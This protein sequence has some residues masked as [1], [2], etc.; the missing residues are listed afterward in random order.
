MET[1]E[2]KVFTNKQEYILYCIIICIATSLLFYPYFKWLMILWKNDPYNTFGYIIPVVSVWII[3]ARK[4]GIFSKSVSYTKWGWVAFLGGLALA[5]FYRWN[6]QAVL[7][8]LALPLVLYGLMMIVWGKERS[9]LLMF[10]IFLLIFLYPWGDILD[11]IM[12]FQLRLFSVNVVCFLFKC[13]GMDAAISGTLIYTGRF[14]VD[15]APACSGL[16]IMN[17]LLFMG[18][19]G[20]HMYNG[21]KS[22]GVIIFLS[23]IPLSIILNTIR[24][25]FTGLAGHFIGEKAALGFYHDVSGMLIFGLALLFLYCE[26]CLFNQ[27][28]ERK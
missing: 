17:V 27:M 2:Q 8:S 18:A 9:R 10:P 21:T 20:A 11:T 4:K 23:V 13:M 14:L 25:F 26:A 6:R 16:T 1:A 5:A 12:G 15:I 28:D 3:Y 24:I 22:K 19:V 7:A